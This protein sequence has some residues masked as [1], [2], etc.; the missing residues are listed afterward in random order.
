MKHNLDDLKKQ[1]HQK[2]TGGALNLSS[3]DSNKINSSKG[4]SYNLLSNKEVKVDSKIKKLS[5][6]QTK[7]SIDSDKECPKCPSDKEVSKR[8][9]VVRKVDTSRGFSM[10]RMLSGIQ[11]PG[12]MSYSVIDNIVKARQC[13]MNKP[14]YFNVMCLG[15]EN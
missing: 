12:K 5:K 4:S 1:V 14:V 6:F 13:D 9:K 11:S 7:K 2:N 3:Y 8:G 15:E 10:P